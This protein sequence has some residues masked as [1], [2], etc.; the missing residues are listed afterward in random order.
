MFVLFHVE[1]RGERRPGRVCGNEDGKTCDC[2]YTEIVIE[3]QSIIIR[4]PSLLLLYHVWAGLGKQ[5]NTLHVFLGCKVALGLM[6]GKL[7][8]IIES[9][10]YGKW[11]SNKT[12]LCD[13]TDLEQTPLVW[14][15]TVQNLG[16]SP[17]QCLFSCVA[18]SVCRD[19]CRLSTST[20]QIYVDTQPIEQ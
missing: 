14:S 11:P 20:M 10:N 4:S 19:M 9:G 2:G 8:Q 5:T 6:V 18:Q 15:G 17:T 7:E 16:S 1:K 13:D 3:I 12:L